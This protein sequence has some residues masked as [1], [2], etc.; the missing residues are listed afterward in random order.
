MNRPCIRG[1]KAFKK[2]CPEKAW[3]GSDGCPAWKEYTIP[4]TDGK[5]IILRDCID[6]LSE[7]WR[8]EALKLL[9][10]NQKATESFRNGMCE[11]APDGKVYPKMDRAVLGLVEILQ[12][13]QRKRLEQNVR[14]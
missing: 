9:E 6:G 12:T 2:G 3:N 1:L 8:F 4:Q 11:S 13:E 5:P 7:H 14:T 10:G